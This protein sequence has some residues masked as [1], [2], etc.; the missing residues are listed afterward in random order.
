LNQRLRF[1]TRAGCSL[2]DEMHRELLA[3]AEAL[4]FELEVLDIDSSEAL[5]ERYNHKVPVLTDAED[6]EICHYFL[7]HQALQGYFATH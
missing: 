5:I 3:A 4:S 7:D 6:E 1:Y 2:C